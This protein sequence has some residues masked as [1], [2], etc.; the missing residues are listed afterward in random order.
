MRPWESFVSEILLIDSEQPFADEL[1][2][3]LENTGFQVT[4]LEDGKEGLEY[5]RSNAPNLIVLC[6][7]LPKMSGY[8]ICN[9]LKKDAELK[10]IPLIITSKEATP[11]T[12]AQH[13]KLKT[14]AEDYLI[15]PFSTEDLIEKIGALIPMPDGAGG[16]DDAL[17]ALDALGELEVSAD[18]INDIELAED[19]LDLGEI[20]NAL[21][22]LEASADEDDDPLG[23]LGD[24][25]DALAAEFESADSPQD[26]LSGLDDVNLDALE[27]GAEDV[28][29][30]GTGDVEPMEEMDVDQALD[31]LG[32][33]FDA[34]T[35]AAPAIPASVSSG[36]GGGGGASSADLEAFAK[37]RRENTE[38][39]AKVSELETRLRAAEEQARS[40]QDALND[41]SSSSSSSA[42][43]TLELKKAVRAKEKELGELNDQLLS[44]EEAVVELQE[45]ID[46]IRREAQEALNTASSKD[47]EIASLTAKAESLEQERDELE[48]TVRDRLQVAEQQASDLR[49]QLDAAR[50]EHESTAAELRGKID[51]AEREAKE[52]GAQLVD[53]YNR[54][55]KEERLRDKAREA[56]SI[57]LS[58]LS[59]DVDDASAEGEGVGAHN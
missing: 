6:V 20:D 29:E 40:S 15:K 37:A 33:T 12:F 7:E 44:K 27:M 22:G 8:S 57:A 38:L 3:A 26:A 21:G 41:A 11:E 23:G 24:D 50:A 45:E 5:A 18:D 2:S 9:K 59:G 30:I 52:S 31:D 25:A 43:E 42:R 51:A 46:R 36:G 55:K 53:A 14:R 4:K 39:K 56:A 35:P 16:G 48:A 17:D 49:G 32:A 28:G 1:L 58:L 54:L 34:A 13:K 19:A 47:A 10:Q